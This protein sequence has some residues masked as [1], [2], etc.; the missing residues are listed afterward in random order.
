M[1]RLHA[2]RT[3]SYPH[4]SQTGASKHYAFIEFAYASVAQIVQETMDNYLLSG[5]ILVCKVV[6]DDEIH[7]KLWIGANRT[8]RPVPKGRRDAVKRA[9]VRPE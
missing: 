6:P 8:F 5:H 7:P 2:H 4:A 9:A 1:S 3:D